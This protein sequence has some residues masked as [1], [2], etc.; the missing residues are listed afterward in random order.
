MVT[1]LGSKTAQNSTEEKL[2]IG[3]KLLNGTRDIAD[4]TNGVC[5]DAVAYTRFLLGANITT[6]ELSQN[7]SMAWKIKFNFTAGFRW[8]GS[9]HIPAGKA[10][11]FYRLA[12]ANIFH[13]AI[14]ASPSTSLTMARSVNGLRLGTSWLQPVS[15]SSVLGRINADGTFNYD[16]TR[17]YV[18]ISNL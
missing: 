3:L 16:G 18:Y 5:Y 13:T 4:F 2:A 17:I 12:D 6:T 15:A 14:T 8:D 9:S 10:L 11:G 7:D 1:S